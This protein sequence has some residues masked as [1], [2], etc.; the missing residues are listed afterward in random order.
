LILQTQL[1]ALMTI[2]LITDLMTIVETR[3]SS[4]TFYTN[5]V[6]WAISY[7]S[8]LAITHRY[9]RKSLLITANQPFSQ[10]DSIFSDSMMTVAAVDR[11]VH[12]G[13]IFEIKSDSYRLQ[14]ATNRLNNS[15]SS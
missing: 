1:I 15:Q 10:W 11:L 9:E 6:Q 12:H 13:T 5:A 8:C 14:A 7:A 4:R 2:A 3:Q